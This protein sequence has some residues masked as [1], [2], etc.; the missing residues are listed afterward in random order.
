MRHQA[1]TSKLAVA[2]ATLSIT[3][4]VASVALR[5]DA[6][7]VASDVHALSTMSAHLRDITGVQEVVT[8][9]GRE[10]RVDIADTPEKREQGLSGRSLLTPDTGMLFVFPQEGRYG[11]WMKD[12]RFAI[13]IVWIGSDGRVVSIAQGVSPDTYPQSFISSEPA[14]YVLELPAGFSDRYDLRVG[15]RIG[16]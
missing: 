2:M 4:V 3:I 1:V 9:A 13:D 11:F 8:V 12:M 14:R 10:V 7:S 16:L 6:P 15:D 5:D